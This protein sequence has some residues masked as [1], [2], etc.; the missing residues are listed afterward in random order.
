MLQRP[1][2]PFK[3]H[4]TYPGGAVTAGQGSD[5][6]SVYENNTRAEIADELMFDGPLKGKLEFIKFKSINAG[7]GLHK[8][9]LFFYTLTNEEYAAIL[10]KLE[11][12][13]RI[14]CSMGKEDLQN[15]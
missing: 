6:L 4:L 15:T 9:G 3:E 12:F 5:T 7:H 8:V 1:F 13:N 14:K 10:L 2:N 11:R